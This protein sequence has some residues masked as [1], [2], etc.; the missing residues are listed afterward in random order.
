MISAT[1]IRFA[2]DQSLL[3][4]LRRLGIQ[5]PIDLLHYYPR[6]YTIYRRCEIASLKPE[7]HVI[8]TGRIQQHRVFGGR[9]RGLTVQAWTIVDKLENAISIKQ[10]HYGSRFQSIHWRYEQQQTYRVGTA[11]SVIGQVK[12][13]EFSQALTIISARVEVVNATSTTQRL[14]I[15]PTYAL[16]KGLNTDALQECIQEALATTE[17]IAR[18][19]RNV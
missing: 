12:F 19:S 16:S 10:F 15:Q 8:V 9:Q 5:T 17:I 7:A 13:D 6:E 2:L 11:I 4:K 3:T 18:L 1:S 14:I